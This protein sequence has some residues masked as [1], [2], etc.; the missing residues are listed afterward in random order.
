MDSEDSKKALK[1]KTYAK[2]YYLHHK[3]NFKKYYEAY[4]KRKIDKMNNVVIQNPPPPKENALTKYQRE[5]KKEERKLQRLEAKK[6]AFIQRL[7]DQGLL[8]TSQD[9]SLSSVPI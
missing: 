3:D 1:T 2:M 9:T 7:V 8:P 5:R 4:K 6:Q